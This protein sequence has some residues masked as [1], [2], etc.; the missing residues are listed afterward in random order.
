MELSKWRLAGWKTDVTDQF[1]QKPKTFTEPE[2]TAKANI[3]KTS[4]EFRNEIA[5]ADEAKQKAF[6]GGDKVE[7]YINELESIRKEE[8]AKGSTEFF[9]KQ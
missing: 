7:D 6:L 3:P 8:E 1:V 9:V 4:E 5:S 2:Q